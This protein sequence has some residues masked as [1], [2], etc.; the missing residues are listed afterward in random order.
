[1]TKHDNA[2]NEADNSPARIEIK[3]KL[4]EI[5]DSAGLEYHNRV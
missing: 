2:L 4:N 3:K 1:M 5:A